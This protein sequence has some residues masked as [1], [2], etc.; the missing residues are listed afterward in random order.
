MVSELFANWRRKRDLKKERDYV[1]AD[2]LAEGRVMWARLRA[3]DVV[4]DETHVRLS[5]SYRAP[6]PG[7]AANLTQFLRK[8]TDYE[9]QAGE[10]SVTGTT[11]AMTLNDDNLP[12]WTIWM[13]DTGYENGGCQ[14]EGWAAASPTAG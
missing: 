14:F 11:Q 2:Q 8:E 13:V 5:F 6:G 9:V 1:L 7:P 10:D 12:G 3:S 4:P